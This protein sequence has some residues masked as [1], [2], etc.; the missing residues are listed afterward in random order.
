MR[1]FK[2]RLSWIFIS[3]K[4]ELSEEFIIEFRKFLNWEIVCGEQNL[5]EE[6]IIKYEDIIN[7]QEISNNEKISLSEEFIKKY[8]Y[9]LDWGMMME[10]GKATLPYI[11]KHIHK[12]KYKHGIRRLKNSGLN[13]SELEELESFINKRNSFEYLYE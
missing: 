8:Q 12:T 4:Q 13:K 5:S 3:E 7:W 11:K 1:D 6:F 9:K 2:D 10:S